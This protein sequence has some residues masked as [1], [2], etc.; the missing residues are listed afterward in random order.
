LRIN[1]YIIADQ[2]KQRIGSKGLPRNP[3]AAGPAASSA[4]LPVGPP[5]GLEPTSAARVARGGKTFKLAV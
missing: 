1:E 3:A 4:S 2:R 5:S